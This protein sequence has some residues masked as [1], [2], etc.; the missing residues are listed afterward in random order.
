MDLNEFIESD[1]VLGSNRELEG[2][3]KLSLLRDRPEFPSSLNVQQQWRLLY[4]M[5][6]P[7]NESKFF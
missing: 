1:Y 3:L 7:V 4:L 5:F 6:G 2:N